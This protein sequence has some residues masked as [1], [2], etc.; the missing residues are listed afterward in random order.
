L[1]IGSLS[2]RIGQAINEQESIEANVIVHLCFGNFGVP[3]KGGNR[4]WFQLRRAHG[5]SPQS[6]DSVENQD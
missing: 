1:I 4:F 5:G 2:L 6:G 3:L